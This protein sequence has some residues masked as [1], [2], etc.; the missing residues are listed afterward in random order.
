MKVLKIE[1]PVPDVINTE[2]DSYDESKVIANDYFFTYDKKNVYS[3]AILNLF[4]KE[5]NFKIDYKVW[6]RFKI[7]E[8]REF[9]KKLDNENCS[10]WGTVEDEIYL[11]EAIKNPK[12]KVE[13]KLTEEIKFGNIIAFGDGFKSLAKDMQNGIANDKWQIIEENYNIST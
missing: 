3:Q 4:Q 5:V 2:L 11:Y 9:V 8:F 7:D 10:L 12:V 1:N 13:F 6:V